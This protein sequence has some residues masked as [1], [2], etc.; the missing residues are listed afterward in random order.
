MK[1][2]I[3]DV[4]HTLYK[5]NT[6]FDYIDFVLNNKNKKVVLLKFKLVKYALIIL[7]RFLHKDLYRYLYIKKLRGFNKSELEYMASEFYRVT[8][9]PLKVASTFDIINKEQTN[10]KFILASASLNLI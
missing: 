5:S 1:I 9:K 2:A 10:Y 7:G 4:C 8:L 6:T 3:V